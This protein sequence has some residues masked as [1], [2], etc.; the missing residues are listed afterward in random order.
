MEIYEF[1]KDRKSEVTEKAWRTLCLP[2]GMLCS[3]KEKNL[4]YREAV[5]IAEKEFWTGDWGEFEMPDDETG[6][7]YWLKK[8]WMERLPYLMDKVYDER[9]RKQ[10]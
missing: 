5:K 6:Q 3:E 1:R 4:F 10:E 9:G 7:V 8:Y 2:V